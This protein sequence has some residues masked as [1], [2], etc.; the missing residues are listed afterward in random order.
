MVAMRRARGN[1]RRMQENRQTVEHIKHSLASVKGEL[2]WDTC[3]HSLGMDQNDFNMVL[4]FVA[5]AEQGWCIE[6]GNDYSELAVDLGAQQNSGRCIVFPL[7]FPPSARDE[8]LPVM[9]IRS[10]N[11]ELYGLLTGDRWFKLHSA[12][13]IGGS[14]ILARY[15]EI[16]GQPDTWAISERRHQVKISALT[17]KDCAWLAQLL[18][19][20][21]IDEVKFLYENLTR[22]AQRGHPPNGRDVGV[23]IHAFR[24]ALEKKRI[25]TTSGVIQIMTT[26]TVSTMFSLTGSRRSFS[27]ALAELVLGTVSVETVIRSSGKRVEIASGKSTWCFKVSGS[28]TKRPKDLETVLATLIRLGGK[29]GISCRVEGAEIRSRIDDAPTL[30]P[31]RGRIGLSCIDLWYSR[32]DVP[33]RIESPDH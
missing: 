28:S 25:L 16:P 33:A 14:V 20:D 18:D 26:R 11:D 13:G 12:H 10:L 4:L 5:A 19:G 7:P 15:V 24:E 17:A 21:P 30:G 31:M 29:R 1:A 32:Y 8:L 23:S 27:R 2:H 22:H 6:A 9:A 3:L